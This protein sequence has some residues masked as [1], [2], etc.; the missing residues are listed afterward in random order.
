[1]S[2]NISNSDILNAFISNVESDGA[3]NDYI[4]T[5]IYLMSSGVDL[6][7]VNKLPAFLRRDVRE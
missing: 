1:M 3:G 6:G 7:R 4:L 5:P 2:S